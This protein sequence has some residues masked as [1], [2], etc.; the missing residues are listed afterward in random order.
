MQ[1]KRSFFNAALFKKNLSRSWPLWGGVTALGCLVPLYLL[2]ALLQLE[3]QYHPADGDFA[4]MLYGV[5][6]YFVPAASFGY[7]ILV[8]MVV[9]SYLYNGRS[10]GMMH[11]L[12]IDR[13]GLFVTNTLS[14]FAM[15]LIPYAVVGL[16][17][18]VIAI[19]WGFMDIL[20]VATTIAAVL[21]MT[22]L[23]FG[24]ATLCAMITGNVF[25]LPAFYLIVNFI[26]PAL[27]GLI[28]ILV[29]SF[30][31]GVS[32][33]Y[34]GAVEFLSPLVQIYRDFQW[35]GMYVTPDDYQYR[36]EGFG[37]V[38][39][40]GLV[41]LV[42]L[43]LALVL[44]LRRKSERSGDVVAFKWL[45]PVF[46]YGVA[47]VSAL[48]LGRLLY[49]LIWESLFQ[50]GD[51]AE[52]VPMAVCMAVAGLVGY[53]AASMLLEKSLRVFRGSV[54]GA[55]VVVV[56]CAVICVG[57][58][59]DLFG[60]EG[61]IPEMDEIDTV[62]IDTSDMVGSRPT[63]S[64]DDDPEMVEMV[65]AL[66]AAIVAQADEI[67][68]DQNREHTTEYGSGEQQEYNYQYLR[69][70]YKL[71]DG[72]TTK[73]RYS[74]CLKR[75]AWENETGFE[76]AFKRLFTSTEF[77]LRQIMG[78]AE[79]E[80]A[81]IYIY[82]HYGSKDSEDL[83][84]EKIYEALLTDANAGNL[85][86]YDPFDDYYNDT[87][88]V[89]IDMEYRVA[90]VDYDNSYHYNYTSV[91]LRPTMVNTIQELLDQAFITLEDLKQWNEER[92]LEG[93]YAEYTYAVPAAVEIGG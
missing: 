60:V 78:D 58:S 16:F 6:T 8:A 18:C 24:M 87:Y 57:T 13:T 62:Y 66:H 4:Q 29:E 65:R 44:Y 47:L 45:R 53:Y 92:G 42:M 83:D 31:M 7:A 37:T 64:A 1:S 28:G 51:Y 41:G 55:V 25:A 86:D 10:V 88:P 20:A 68:A 33:G 67:K 43:G 71:K 50:N 90:D 40:Y 59:M 69:I 84:T 36:L 5:D 2:L 70:E 48:T 61:Y 73:R 72:S 79:G 74:L 52:A 93:G 81:N 63:L 85:Y 80:L 91:N 23:F 30:L 46:R 89:T 49:A 21:L 38:A 75:E 3:Q 34:S 54:P 76:A 22:V 35:E 14:G 82:N 17:T 19:V 26:A 9:W 12:P 56:A 39:I 77:Q 27:D 32:N 11:T 15:L